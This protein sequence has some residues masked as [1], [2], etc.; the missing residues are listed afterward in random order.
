MGILGACLG[1]FVVVQAFG[2][3]LDLRSPAPP[4]PGDGRAVAYGPFDSLSDGA[5]PSAETPR[6]YIVNGVNVGDDAQRFPHVFFQTPDGVRFCGGTAIS[7][8]HV[9]TAAHCFTFCDSSSGSLYY[10]TPGRVFY[11]SVDFSVDEALDAPVKSV[12]V[13]KA[14]SSLEACSDSMWYED[15]IAVIELATP[16]DQ[17]GLESNFASISSV[18]LIDLGNCVAS[19]G[20]CPSAWVVGSGSTQEGQ[21]T[22][23]MPLQLKKAEV[24][25]GTCPDNPLYDGDDL[26]YLCSDPGEAASN[27]CKSVC[28]A[29]RLP[30]GSNVDSCQGAKAK[31]SHDTFARLYA[32]ERTTSFLM[33]RSLIR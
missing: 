30:D 26:H 32:P 1:V 20:G 15:D 29:N 5:A 12:F 21:S 9:L 2:A 8:T 4:L 23:N 11:G 19:N 24:H 3:A 18:P 28:A 13:H 25:V 14:F 10:V 7:P 16:L 6:P 22:Q 17:A 27:S 33:K 31:L